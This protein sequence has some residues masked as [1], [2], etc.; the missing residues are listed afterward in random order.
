MGKL[1]G[2]G[3]YGAVYKARARQTSQNV[4]IKRCFDGE[5]GMREAEVLQEIGKL[6]DEHEEKVRGLP[7]L[8]NGF[9]R[10]NEFFIVTELLG[11]SLATVIKK[12]GA[13]PASYV[14]SIGRQLCQAVHC[15]P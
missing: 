14:Q 2:K 5:Q 12:P 9:Q 11:P 7:I 3:T 6:R 8:L 1:I 4:A 10:E 13:F 15:R